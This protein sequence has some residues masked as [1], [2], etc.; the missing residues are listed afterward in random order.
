MRRLL[1][2]LILLFAIVPV[3]PAEVVDRITAV[4]G[5]R[6]IT[7]SLVREQLRIA[8]LF[9]GQPL[10]DNRLAR[11]EMRD[12][13]IERALVLEEMTVSRYPMPERNEMRPQLEALK[14][15]LGTP[16]QY[17]RLLQ[18]YSVTEQQLLESLRNQ[19]AVIRFTTYRFRPGIQITARE[20]QDYYD[21]RWP[22]KGPKPPLDDVREQIEELLRNEQINVLLSRWLSDVRNQTHIETYEEPVQ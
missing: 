1:P 13:L 10:V 22:G 6:I 16:E 14:K 5:R 8:A 3:L 21:N 19:Q 12:R 2:P 17:A 11:A 20:I 4:V 18:T 7:D 9:N 15:E